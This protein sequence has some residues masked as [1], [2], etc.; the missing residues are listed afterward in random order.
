MSGEQIAALILGVVC[1]GVAIIFLT[2][3]VWCL[4]GAKEPGASADRWYAAA[5][6]LPAGLFLFWAYCG[7]DI[8]FQLPGGPR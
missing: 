7:V 8:V 1:L 6:M 4:E 5:F 3:A 2:G